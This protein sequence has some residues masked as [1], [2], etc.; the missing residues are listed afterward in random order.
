MPRRVFAAAAIAATLTCGG[1]PSAEAQPLIE[2]VP[3]DAVAYL[4][5][6]GTATLADDYAQSTLREVVALMEPDRLDAAWRRVVPALR[7]GLDGADADSDFDAAYRHFTDLWDASVRGAVAAYLELGPGALDDDSP[8]RPSVLRS[9]VRLTLMWRPDTGDDREA[10]LEGLKYFADRTVVPA[11]LDVD[12]PVLTLR[13][14]HG[15]VAAPPGTFPG[16]VPGSAPGGAP[17]ITVPDVPPPGN[18]A[19]RQR[20]SLADTARF[21]EAWSVLDEPGPLAVYAD[22][23]GLLPL[24]RDV[25][26]DPAEPDRAR[27]LDG[28]LNTLQLERLGPSVATA[29]F[30]GRRW[31]TQAYV[32][33]PMPRAGLGSLLDAPTLTADGLGLPPRNATWA[34]ALSLDPGTLVDLARAAAGAAG[35]D[36]A[37]RFEGGLASA[38]ATLGVDLENELLRGLGSTWSIYLDPDAAGDSPLGLTLVNPLQDPEGVERGLR[39]AQQLANLVSS[40]RDADLEWSWR[41]H[42]QTYGDTEVHTL[43]SPAVAPSWAVAGGR[44]IV[45]LS[46]QAVLAAVDR[47]EQPGSL[48]DRDD[49]AELVE[50]I[51]TRRL[52]S[53]AW[54]DLPRT[55]ATAYPGLLIAEHTLTG[56]ASGVSGQPMPAVLPPLVRLRPLLEPASAIGWV[57]DAGWHYDSRMPFPGSTLL[58]PAASLA[59]VAGGLGYAGPRP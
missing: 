21:A 53:V 25:L 22:P 5:W 19:L 55:A 57:D 35:P 11:E 33:A 38:T 32:A 4:G 34:A 8:R 12:G 37:D 39:A 18:A 6:A 54:I 40:Q 36:T 56:V 13:L 45:A 51:G 41:I 28:L 15:P 31:R 23:S 3:P 7:R 59:P 16:G 43:A 20:P 10:L 24:L 42:T 9:R 49:F 58:S 44:L 26:L 2:R 27:V 52:T 30:D 48:E 46:P 50:R 17:G 29:G 1:G 14:N 47:I